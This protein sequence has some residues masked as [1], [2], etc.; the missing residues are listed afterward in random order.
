MPELNAALVVES[1]MLPFWQYRALER[2]LEDGHVRV[3]LVLLLTRDQRLRRSWRARGWEFCARLVGGRVAERSMLELL[4]GVPVMQPNDLQHAALDELDFVLKLTPHTQALPEAL[5][6]ARFGVWS[7]SF[8]GEGV[9]GVPPGALETYHACETSMVALV[10]SQAPAGGRDVLRWARQR[11]RPGCFRNSREL[12][13]RASELPRLAVLDLVHGTTASRCPEEPARL[14]P[15][16]RFPLSRILARSAFRFLRRGIELT[17]F[18]EHWS[19]LI[20]RNQ[21]FPS[22]DFFRRDNAVAELRFPSWVGYGADPFIVEAGNRLYLLFEY[23]DA[24]TGRIDAAVL[25]ENLRL[26]DYAED[27]APSRAHQSYPFVMKTSQGWLLMPEAG[28]SGAV[29]YY[30]LE[31]LVGPVRQS[32]TLI[33]DFA[34]VDN[35]ICF[36]AGKYWMFNSRA[37]QGLDHETELMLWWADDPRGPWTAHP[38][39]PIQIDIAGSRPAGPLFTDAQ[40]VL[41]RPAQ[42]G[43]AGY[44]GGLVLKRVA[45]LDE[46]RF[47]EQTVLQVAPRDVAPEAIGVHHFCASERYVAVDYRLRRLK[48]RL[49]ARL[50]GK[51]KGEDARTLV[52][53]RNTR[54][55]GPGEPLRP[56]TTAPV[57]AAARHSEVERVLALGGTRLRLP[58]AQ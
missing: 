18:D 34:G 15:P 8:S 38:A 14:E 24:G 36:H 1:E 27:L 40:G 21:G 47:E 23:Y 51:A 56:A 6:Q 3:R 32:G 33:E 29:P 4:R 43:S 57:L 58:N 22:K 30:L 55:G 41:Y 53:V 17:L 44:G 39:N 35:T 52:E 9:P 50:V 28:A 37:V 11:T 10:S 26:V 20:F 5:A 16:R 42:N 7:L 13:L 12:L 49:L 25:D 2:L 48:S 19:I 45:A 31:D 46:R 54:S